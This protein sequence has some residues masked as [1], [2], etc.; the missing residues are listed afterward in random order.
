MQYWKPNYISA[1]LY[2]YTSISTD[3]SLSI[4]ILRKQDFKEFMDTIYRI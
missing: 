1:L 3:F 2:H 4:Y